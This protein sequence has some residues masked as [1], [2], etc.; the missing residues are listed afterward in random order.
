MRLLQLGTP[1]ETFV[2]D[3]LEVSDLLPL[4]ELLEGGAVPRRVARQV[5]G[6][7][8][9]VWAVER[10][11]A[12]VRRAGRQGLAASTRPSRGIARRGGARTDLANR[13]RGRRGDS[14]DGTRWH[15]ARSSS[16][17]GARGEGARAARPGRRQP[18]V[19]LPATRRDTTSRGPR[20]ATQ[21]QQPQANHRCLP[22][23]GDR[24]P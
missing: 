4:P 12:R 22:D 6:E 15:Q 17:E 10:G 11:T 19:L 13:V 1:E 24:A 9:L 18:G 21:P 8:R 3:A 5:R 16:L 14:R 7:E 23:P 20:A 2:I